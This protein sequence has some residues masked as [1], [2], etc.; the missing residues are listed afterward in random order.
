MN[1]G[2]S[3]EIDVTPAN[4]ASTVF[5]AGASAGTDTLWAQLRLNDGLSGWQQFNV[6]VPMPTAVS[7]QVPSNSS[8]QAASTNDQFVFRP[9]IGVEANIR[10]QRKAGYGITYRPRVPR[11]PE[12]V[13]L[14]WQEERDGSASENF[15]EPD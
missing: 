9:G 12:A 2:C 11:G 7:S 4:V 5:N 8:T 14:K 15:S 1:A 10:F 3:D 13:T 6:T